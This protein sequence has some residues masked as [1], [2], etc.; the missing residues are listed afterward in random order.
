[1]DINDAELLASHG[2]A[3]SWACLLN[4]T[5]KRKKTARSV[6]HLLSPPP[7]TLSPHLGALGMSRRADERQPPRGELGRTLRS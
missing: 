6:Y 4:E 2:P 7:S 1:M 3:G 5:P